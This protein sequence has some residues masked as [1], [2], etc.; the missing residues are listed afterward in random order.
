MV[1]REEELDKQFSIF[2]RLRYADHTGYVSCFTCAARV[3]YSEMDCG[4]W[5]VRA[6]HG[7]RW[8]KDNC[9]AQCTECNRV[10]GGRPEVFE[11]NL[12]DNLG[13]ERVKRLEEL[14]ATPK[15]FTDEEMKA[16][17]KNYKM[18]NERMGKTC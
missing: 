6:N 14:A 18:L 7:T 5:K 12:R 16:L 3:K 8:E 11:E 17:I 10:Y 15:Q 13:D 1:N 9:E 2:I 4:H